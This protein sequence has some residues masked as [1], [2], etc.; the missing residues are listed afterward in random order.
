MIEGGA[1]GAIEGD[2]NELGVDRIWAD[3]GMEAC[4]GEPGL[5]MSH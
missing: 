2:I 5:G 4:E 1:G 3:R